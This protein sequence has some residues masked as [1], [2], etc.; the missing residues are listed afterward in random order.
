MTAKALLGVTALIEA[1]T[2]AL[3]L[4]IPAL[5]TEMLLGAALT[6]PESLIV[7]R[8]AGA[9]LLSIGLTC[10]L[11]RHRS[12]T[13]LSVGLIAGLLLYN[14]TAGVLLAYAASVAR[15]QGVGIWPALGLHVVLLAWC[16]GCLRQS[17][18]EVPGTPG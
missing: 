5:T 8:I 7:A 15:M 13:A 16:A 11:E 10:W 3:L 2:G 17:R 18:A 14:A 12:G 4:F 6:S 9:A 1:G